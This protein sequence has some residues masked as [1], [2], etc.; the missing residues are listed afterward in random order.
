MLDFSVTF[1]LGF[2]LVI[3]IKVSAIA[4]SMAIEDGNDFIGLSK[5]KS[6]YYDELDHATS[7]RW[8]EFREHDGNDEENVDDGYFLT[9][10]APIRIPN[11]EVKIL[12]LS[13]GALN[14][15]PAR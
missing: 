8:V 1:I 5:D 10:F 9:N 15:K 11:Y 12:I 13:H 6:T 14:Y 7:K 4:R 3:V 2:A